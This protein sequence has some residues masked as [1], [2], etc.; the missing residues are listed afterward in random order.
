MINICLTK[1]TNDP[2]SKMMM[3]GFFLALNDYKSFKVEKIFGYPQK[4]YDVIVLVGIRS[5]VKRNLDKNKIL[6]FC[7]KLIDM[8]DSAMDPRRNFE[9]IYF[10]FIPSEKK[11]HEHYYY[12]P[13][14][15]LEKYLYPAKKKSK[16]LNIYVDLFH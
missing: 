7:T 13:K 6:P 9:D 16:I 14:F 11:L 15:I 10:Y 4:K 3:E 8:G 1:F 12:L 2:W 5:I